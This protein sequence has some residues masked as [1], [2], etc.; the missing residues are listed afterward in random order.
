MSQLEINIDSTALSKSNCHLRLFRTIIG[1]IQDGRATGGY[2]ERAHNVAM[3]YGIGI[4]KFL[5][6]MYKSS[7][8]L[9]K[10]LKAGRDLFIA[11][12]KIDDP[13]K[14]WLSL[15]NHLSS[16]CMN[17]WE[18]VQSN[19]TFEVL[20]FNGQP[21]T[22][23]TFDLP[24][25][26]DEY[27][28]V[29]LRGTIDRIGKIKNGCYCIRDWKTTSAWDNDGYFKQYELSRQLLTYRLACW[30]QSQKYPDSLL[31]KIGATT[32][33]LAID[34]IFLDQDSNKVTVESSEV[35][36]FQQKQLDDFGLMLDDKCR[37]ISSMVKTGYIPKT[38]I[39]TGTCGYGKTR[40][41]FW[42]MC[43]SPDNVAEILLKRL[44][45]QKKFDPLTYNE[46]S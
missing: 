10:S 40:C 25:Y 44:F 33:G 21:A 22:E 38:G 28:K 5:D 15:P 18:A 13:K 27:V 31:G 32:M 6:T 29:S 9:A 20:E 8:D 7:G 34:A 39:I 19:G 12:P 35:F 37:E 16:T 4:H 46:I 45:I 17:V 26:E 42:D 24:Y 43:K 2:T 23:I 30:L 3:V 36:Q 41:C 11:M 14:P 1:E